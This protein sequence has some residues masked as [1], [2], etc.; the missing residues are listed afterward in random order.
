MKIKNL[1]KKFFIPL[2]ISGILL[3]SSIGAYADSKIEFHNQANC[4]IWVWLHWVDHP[5]DHPGPVTMV[6]AEIESKESWELDWEKA[7]G[8][9]IIEW[10]QAWV[11][12]AET[13]GRQLEIEP[14]DKIIVIGLN[15]VCIE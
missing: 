3:F 7:T 11:A 8:H 10:E 15:V 5:F 6:V 2:L 14:D 4:T 12:G 13:H 1:L 9:Y